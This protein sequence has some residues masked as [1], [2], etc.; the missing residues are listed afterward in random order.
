MDFQGSLGK[1]SSSSVQHP[2]QMVD[3]MHLSKAYEQV[4]TIPFQLRKVPRMNR[5]TSVFEIIPLLSDLL[6]VLGKVSLVPSCPHAFVQLTE[7]KEKHFAFISN[8]TRY[9]S[10]ECVVCR[11]MY[12]FSSHKV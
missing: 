3:L 11:C 2:R 12:Q 1:V 5:K 8:S 7:T 9:L 10:W 4:R 6:V